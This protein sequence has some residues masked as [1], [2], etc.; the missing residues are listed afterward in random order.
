MKY[1]RLQADELVD[2]RDEFVQFLVANTITAEDWERI[3]VDSP[4]R[5]EG[6]LDIFSDIV[7]DKIIAKIEYLIYKTPDDI[8]TFHCTADLIKLRGLRI[9][10]GQGIDLTQNLAP[11]ELM[12]LLRSSGA[13]VQVYAAEKRYQPNREQELFRMLEGGAQIDREGALYQALVEV[14]S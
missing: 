3:K 12:A 4:E 2:L 13:R 10:G 1:R 11:E 14:G 8:K 7:F 5:A 6:L 9:E